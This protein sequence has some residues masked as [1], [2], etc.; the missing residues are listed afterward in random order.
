[1]TWRDTAL[2]RLLGIEL[3]I[4]QAP[5]SGGPSTPALAAAVS[6]AGGLGSLGVAYLG[7]RVAVTVASPRRHAATSLPVLPAGGIMDGRVIAEDLADVPLPHPALNALTRDI[8]RRAAEL[9]RADLLSLWAGTGVAR[10]R[11]LG[12]ADLVRTPSPPR[13]RRR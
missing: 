9:G 3:P 4:V 2:T 1:M 11:D 10:I 8:R 6:E 13:P 12:A 7:A 5:L